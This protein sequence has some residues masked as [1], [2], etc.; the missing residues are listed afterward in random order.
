[1]GSDGTRG[2]SQADLAERTGLSQPRISQIENGDGR[3][4]PTYAVIRKIA[5][6]CG[7]DWGTIVRGIL[8]TPVR[9]DA[10][11]AATASTQVSQ[12]HFDEPTRTCDRDNEEIQP[13]G[14]AAINSHIQHAAFRCR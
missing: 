12:K 1:M 13:D 5:L 3:D 4:G 11:T 6:A 10:P 7:V 14:I 8:V 9:A 2:I